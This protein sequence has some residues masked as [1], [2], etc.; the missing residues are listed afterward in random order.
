LSSTDA[1]LVFLDG[2]GAFE[3]WLQ[4]RGGAIAARGRELEGLPPLIDPETKRPVPVA[5]VV[6]GDTVTVHWL[7]LPAGLAPAQAIAAARLM[8]SEVSAQ[9]LADMH[10]AVGPEREGHTARAVAL[11]PALAMANWI[12]RLQEQGLDPDIVLPEPLLLARPREGYVRF[13]R[14]AVPIFRGPSDAFSME[15]EL[16]EAI[17]AEAKV[18]TL[19]EAEFEDGLGAA[20][21]DPAVNLRQ[22]P[23]AKRRRWR[24]EWKRL[25]RM[26]LLSLGILLVTLAIH[27]VAILRY[28]YAADALEME[29]KGIAGR[30]LPRSTV[31]SNA[32]LQLQER[33]AELGGSGASYGSMSSAVFGAVR[34]SAN[35]EVTGIVFN[36]D[37]S[38]R[39]TVQADSPASLAGLQQRIQASG[40]TA[41]MGEVRSGGGRPT[42]EVTVRGR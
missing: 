38:M 8:A 41:D 7:E 30:A 17:V 4:L 5:A 39:V 31:V 21:A 34:A 3:G 10:V 22:G 12:G 27:L 33:L 18:E 2:L 16:A 36:P 14:G 32:P 29:A 11:V 13:D 42:A 15:A 6:P 23:F 1:L 25:R 37:R 26:A 40:F 28:T 9:P 35:V 20:I 24:I 19:G